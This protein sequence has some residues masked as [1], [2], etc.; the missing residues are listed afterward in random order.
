MLNKYETFALAESLEE[1]IFDYES[2][3]SLES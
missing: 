1:N 2:T 3:L